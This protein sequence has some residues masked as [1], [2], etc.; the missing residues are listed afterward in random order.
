MAAAAL[1][2]AERCRGVRACWLWRR[3]I[4]PFLFLCGP[5]GC[6]TLCDLKVVAVDADAEAHGDADRLGGRLAGR[7]ARRIYLFR[8]MRARA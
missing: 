8:E 6:C 1:R 2:T 4:K 3:H 5:A 7:D